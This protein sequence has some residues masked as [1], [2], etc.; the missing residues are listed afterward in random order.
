MIP[1]QHPVRINRTITLQVEAQ[2]L[3]YFPPGYD[4]SQTER[5]PLLV[6]LHGSGERGNNLELLKLHGPP[7]HLAKGEHFPLIIASVQCPEGSWWD[8]YVLDAVLDELLE[9]HRVDEDR[10][11]L[12]GLSM[13]GYGTWAWGLHSP[14]RFAAL[15]PICGGGNDFLACR[16][17]HMPIWAFHGAKDRVV[18]LEESE[19]MVK[20][21]NECGGNAKLTVYPEATHNS[22]SMTYE[23]PEFWSWMLSQRRNAK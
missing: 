20:A 15:A 13:G 12:S 18:L 5:W 4:A 6:F 17:S 11:Y 19:K 7:K 10:V 3:L 14:E 23:N 9:N 21:I 1:E 2:Y 16:L 22:W 8:P